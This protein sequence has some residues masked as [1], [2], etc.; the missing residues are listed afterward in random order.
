MIDPVPKC[1]VCRHFLPD[2]H[3]NPSL[4]GDTGLCRRFPPMLGPIAPDPEPEPGE[5]S[6][7]DEVRVPPGTFARFPAVFADDVCGEFAAVPDAPAE[8]GDQ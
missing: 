1:G 6:D 7:P 3:D 8:D 2:E 4:S 5:A